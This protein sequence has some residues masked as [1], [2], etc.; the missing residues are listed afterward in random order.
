MVT[1]SSASHTTSAGFPAPRGAPRSEE[2]RVGEKGRDR[3]GPDNL[4]KKKKRAA[5]GNESGHSA[6]FAYAPVRSAALPTL[7]HF[8]HLCRVAERLATGCFG[9]SASAVSLTELWS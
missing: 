6:F 3:G 8:F 9:D 1:V 5:V 7:A 4:K 2:R